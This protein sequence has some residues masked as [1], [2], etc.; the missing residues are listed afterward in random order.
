[1]SVQERPAATALI[2]RLCRAHRDR[3]PD[4]PLVTMVDGVWAYCIAHAGSDHDWQVIDPTTR[5]ALEE[6]DSV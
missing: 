3:D 6:R 4:G 1:M 2:E 5:R